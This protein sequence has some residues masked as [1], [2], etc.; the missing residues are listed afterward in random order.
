MSLVWDLV[1]GSRCLVDTRRGAGAN[2]EK[3][4]KLCGCMHVKREGD[5][6]LGRGNNGIGE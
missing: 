5:G 6:N 3:G 1:L 2:V 4:E